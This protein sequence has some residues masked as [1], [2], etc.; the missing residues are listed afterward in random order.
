MRPKSSS[1]GLGQNPG[2][3]P[4]APRMTYFGDGLVASADG[5]TVGLVAGTTAANAHVFTL[6]ATGE[7]MS[8]ND[9]PA[10][11]QGPGFSTQSGPNLALST[12]GSRAAW[13]TLDALGGECFSR[14]VPVVVT[15]PDS[16]RS[17]IP[18]L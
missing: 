16:R 3:P 8:V 2:L 5:N 17:F 13:K 15:P 12:D 1:G 14:Q 4:R 9:A 11:I 6:R 18:R 10:P 7:A